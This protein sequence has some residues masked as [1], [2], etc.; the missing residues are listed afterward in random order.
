MVGLGLVVGLVVNIS[1]QHNDLNVAN[2][3]QHNHS[4]SSATVSR[5]EDVRALRVQAE[6]A[7]AAAAE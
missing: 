6:A 3:P 2:T 5:A 7:A 1:Q 4:G